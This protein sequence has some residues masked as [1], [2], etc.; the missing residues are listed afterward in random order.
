VVII[1]EG[2]LRQFGIRLALGGRPADLRR[3]LVAESLAVVGIGATAGLLI[4][5]GPML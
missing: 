1:N 5:G 4:A 3:A 2:F